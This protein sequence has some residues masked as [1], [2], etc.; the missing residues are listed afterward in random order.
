M[1]SSDQHACVEGMRAV[2]ILHMSTHAWRA[3]SLWRPRWIRTTMVE[4]FIRSNDIF[5]SLF[6]NDRKMSFDL[7]DAIVVGVVVSGLPRTTP[8][9]WS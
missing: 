2:H 6:N 9:S 7:V 4:N 1:L 8:S 5:R 3:V